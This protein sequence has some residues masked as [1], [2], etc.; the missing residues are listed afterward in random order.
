MSQ[1]KHARHL[2]ALLSEH[3][4]EFELLDPQATA[5]AV[6]LWWKAFSTKESPE[7][8]FVQKLFWHCF[9]FEEKSA[10]QHEAAIGAYEAAVA[11]EVL[12]FSVL[13][14]VSVAKVRKRAIPFPVLRC[15][16]P[17]W[18]LYVMDTAASWTF[19]RTHEDSMNLGP[20]FSR[21]EWR[22]PPAPRKRK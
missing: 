8:W 5:D 19:V 4:V 22:N 16:S 12:L 17:I 20:Y 2:S 7:G 13:D 6:G 10:L 21:R 14:A 15:L 9:S 3:G 11:K 18:D 1:S